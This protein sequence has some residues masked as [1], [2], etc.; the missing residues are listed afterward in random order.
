MP[1]PPNPYQGRE[2]MLREVLPQLVPEPYV[3]YVDEYVKFITDIT[4]RWWSSDP[5]V[6]E[7]YAYHFTLL[8]SRSNKFNTTRAKKNSFFAFLVQRGYVS[9]Y[10]VMRDKLV[11]GGESLYT[12]LRMYRELLGR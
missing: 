9:S 1:D 2:S 12:W 7:K 4:E 6:R 10:R 8:Y 3:R 5:A 11:A